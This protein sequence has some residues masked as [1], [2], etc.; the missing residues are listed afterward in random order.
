VSINI[1]PL[2]P[3]DKAVIID[4]LKVLPEFK[5]EEVVVAEELIDACLEDPVQSGYYVLVAE[6][7]DKVLGYICY[8]PTPLTRGTWDIYWM[9]VERDQQGRGIGAALMAAAETDI[10]RIGGRLAI[11][12]TSG[13]PLYEKTRRFHSHQGYELV[14]TIKD[15]YEPG[16]DKLILQKRFS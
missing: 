12:E 9:A 10:I 13:Q 6:M 1:R 16:D 8:G 4:I 7:E 14:C 3:A 15:F 11:I 5:P 2:K